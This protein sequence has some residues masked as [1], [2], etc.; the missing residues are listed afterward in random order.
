ML[1]IT[2][3][4][5]TDLIAAGLTHGWTGEELVE[6]IKNEGNII[7]VDDGNFT[8]PN[9]HWLIGEHDLHDENRPGNEPVEID[10]ADCFTGQ[11]LRLAG[12]AC[13]SYGQDLWIRAM[14]LSVRA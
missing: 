14:A 13:D 7:D 1:R 10:L 3:I 6:Y 2:E 4:A 9:S 5:V 12:E 8:L 11:L